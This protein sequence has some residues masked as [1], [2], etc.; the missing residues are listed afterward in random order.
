MAVENQY[1]VIKVNEL[2]ALDVAQGNDEIIINDV[3]STPLETKKISAQDFAISIKD[4]ILPIAS[5]TVLGG[6]KIGEG[7]EINPLTG[8]LTNGVLILDDL[9]DVAI[10]NPEVGQVIR[11]DGLNWVNQSEG[12]ITNIIAGAGLIGGGFEGDVELSVNTGDGI[13]IKSDAVTFNAGACL[14][15]TN[16]IVNVNVGSGLTVSNNAVAVV[17][18]VGLSIANN[19]VN[20]VPGTGLIQSGPGIRADIGRGLRYNGNKFECVPGLN[21]EYEIGR[22]HV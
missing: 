2:T 22:A 15:I 16:D 3:D 21:L 20:F 12:G 9:N 8:V 13:S 6:V 19:A 10:L 1:N 11:Y 4:Y 17:P 7:L 5:E 14:S 18:G